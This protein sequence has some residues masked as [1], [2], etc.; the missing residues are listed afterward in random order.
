MM[1]KAVIIKAAITL[2]MLFSFISS[3][4]KFPLSDY[5]LRDYNL[6]SSFDISYN[7]LEAKTTIHNLTLLNVP[8]SYYGIINSPFSQ[9]RSLAEYHTLF[10]ARKRRSTAISLTTGLGFNH[11]DYS[12]SESRHDF[13][14][15]TSAISKFYIKTDKAVKNHTQLL[16]RGLINL[17]LYSPGSTL[18]LSLGGELSNHYGYNYEEQTTYQNNKESDIA[19]YDYEPSDLSRSVAIGLLVNNRLRV[20]HGIYLPYVF[21]EYSLH[22]NRNPL[23]APGCLGNDNFLINTRIT[24]HGRKEKINTGV[25]QAGIKPAF[26]HQFSYNYLL[27]RGK[28]IRGIAVKETFVQYSRKNIFSTE[29]SY[30]PTKQFSPAKVDT[31]ILENDLREFKILFNPEICIRKWISFSVPCTYISEKNSFPHRHKLLY[32]VSV[33]K[34]YGI[35]AKYFTLAG[36][37]HFRLKIRNSILL[38]ASLKTGELVLNMENVLMHYDQKPYYRM[39]DAAFMLS[40]SEFIRWPGN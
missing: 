16:Y 5:I 11:S 25:I 35:A 27:Y 14:G 23:R 12:K 36:E 6:S 19:V 3:M 29:Y 10:F 30:A 18:N 2:C 40:V 37:L 34:Q 9:E 28:L 33:R 7:R 21:G 32:P 17:C 24:W 31:A 13:A 39:H 1:A 22:Q 26:P 15:D 38:Q 8:F 20:V 4:D